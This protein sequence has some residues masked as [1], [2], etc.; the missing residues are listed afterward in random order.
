MTATPATIRDLFLNPRLTYTSAAA[1]EAIGMSV[2]DVEGWMQVGE[3]EGIEVRGN[4][5]LPWEELVSFAMGFWE[6]T[7]IEAALGIELAE[8]LPELFDA[9][10]SGGAHPAHGSRRAGETSGARRKIG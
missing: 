9:V 8:A 10:R 1:A 2:E 4:V 3:L 6:Q 5:V 7:D